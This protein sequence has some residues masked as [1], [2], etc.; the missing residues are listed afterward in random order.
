MNAAD[1]TVQRLMVEEGFRATA[2]RDTAGH[3]TIGYG[4]NIDAGWSKGL[5]ACVLRY[6]VNDVVTQLQTF[7]WWPAL[8]DVRASV[9]I[10]LA[11]NNGLHGLLNYP[12]ML[13][14][15]GSHSWADASAELLN[16]DA[17]RALP[18]RYNPLAA[19]LLSGAQSV[20]SS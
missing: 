1:L 14:F 19:L 18:N 16:S 9:I 10:D 3:L 6:Q 17:A 5:A 12:R 7:W 20:V 4:T 15:I 2:Y 13:G 11:F 8:D